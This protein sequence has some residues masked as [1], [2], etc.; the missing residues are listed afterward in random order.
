[1]GTHN[2]EERFNSLEG[3]RALACIG[4]ALGHFV[5]AIWIKQ[6]LGIIVKTPLRVLFNATGSAVPTLFIISGFVLCIKYFQKHC[7]E[8]V[9]IDIIKRWFRLV[10][11]VLVAN[12]VVFIMMKCNLL[13]NIEVGQTLGSELLGTANNFAPAIKDCLY[14]GFVGYFIGRKQTYIAP[15][16]TMKIEFLGSILVLATV[17]IFKDN[18]FRWVFYVVYLLFFAKSSNTYAYLVI[19][20][21]ICDLCY[22]TRI[23]SFLKKHQILTNIILT[24]VFY[25]FTMYKGKYWIT[26][27]IIALLIM[28][29][30]ASKAAEYIFGNR[31]M[32]WIGRHSFA[33]YL[34]H[35]PVYLSFSSWYYLKMK[36]VLSYEM[37]MKSE[38]ILTMIIVV[39]LSWFMAKYIENLGNRPVKW[40]SANYHKLK[41]SEDIMEFLPVKVKK[42]FKNKLINR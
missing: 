25:E 18:R 12:I 20:M 8:Q 17:G 14:D 1:M 13:Y 3:I 26:I 7:Y 38:L 5:Q 24:V 23:V 32:R 37:L 27:V 21:I 15:L 39:G 40:I 33:I 4:V 11:A 34:V 10:P 19:G 9:P 30:M 29:L 41:D 22:S 31:L 6:S 28:T 2:K 42:I 16:W 36:D 35:W